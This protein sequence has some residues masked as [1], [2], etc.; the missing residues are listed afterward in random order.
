MVD[1]TKR[2]QVKKPENKENGGKQ[3]RMTEDD[4]AKLDKDAVNKI[5]HGGK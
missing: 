4:Y 1:K 2:T 3:V 5:K